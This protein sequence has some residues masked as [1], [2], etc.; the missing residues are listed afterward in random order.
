MELAYK[1]KKPIPAFI[2]NAP[3]L[4]IGAQMYYKAF[5]RLGTCRVNAFSIGAIPVTAIIEYGLYL[6]LSDC[7]LDD[8]ITVITKVD[9]EYI[10]EISEESKS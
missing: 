2:E 7:E 8:F 4:E 5:I 10:S 1:S 3:E 6:G 9:A